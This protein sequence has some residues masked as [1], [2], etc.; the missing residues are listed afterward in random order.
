MKWLS[1]IFLVG[2]ISIVLCQAQNIKFKTYQVEDGLSNN[3]VNDFENDISGGL[4]IATWDG[5]NYFDGTNFQV[6]KHRPGD[7]SSLPGNFIFNLQLDRN[8]VL[9][10]KS[11]TQ[12]ISYKDGEGFVSFYF[13]Q[14]IEDFGLDLKGEL[15]LDVAG[16][17]FSFANGEF[18]SCPSC[19]SANRSPNLL[20]ELLTRN[21]PD[22]EINKVL[23]DDLGQ[24]WYAT[25]KNGLF[26]LPPESPNVSEH[27]FYNYT[28]DAFYPYSINSN[29]IYTIHEDVFGNVWVG[30]K[31]GGISMA[32]R[33]SGQIFSVFPHPTKNPAI[34]EETIRA[35]TQG[36]NGEIW[37]GYYNSGLFVSKDGQETF[38]KFHLDSAKFNKDWDRVRSLHTDGTGKIWVGTYA[39]IARIDL[40][41]GVRYFTADDN[42]YI[43]NNRNYNFAEADE[44][45]TLWVACWGGLAKYSVSEDAFVHFEG[46]EKLSPYNIRHVFDSN[47]I[48]YLATESNGVIIWENG[49]FRFLDEK[50]GL[51]SPSVYS[52]EKDAET[53]NIWIATMGGINI[54]HPDKGMLLQITELDGL[55]SQLVYG[56]LPSEDYMWASTTNG[57]SRISKKD[58]Q[59][60][61]LS[62]SE[63]WQGA[64][65]SEGGFYD[66]ERGVL[67]FSGVGGL[68]YFHPKQLLIKD[69]LPILGIVKP[70]PEQWEEYLKE[71][72]LDLKARHV[73]FTQT[74]QNKIQYQLAPLQSGWTD[75]G[76]DFR[77]LEASLAPGEYTLTL[78]NSQEANS[79]RYITLAITIPRPFWKSPVPWLIIG[80]LFVFS[81]LLWRSRNTKIQRQNL[82]KKVA[83]RTE[84][85]EKQKLELEKI[86][87]DLD[88]KNKEVSDQKATL[89]T[90]HNRHKDSDFEIEQFKN[91]MLGQF[92]LPLSELKENI[93]QLNTKSRVR[94]DV[95]LQQVNEIMSQIRDWDRATELERSEGYGTSLTILKPLLKDVFQ[96]IKPKLK[97]YQI[98]YEEKYQLEESWVEMDVMGF[99]LFWQYL[100][101]E[102]M[103]YLG[104]NS[105]LAV[106]ATS[107]QD[108]IQVKLKISSSLLTSNI[109]EIIKYSPYIKAAYGLLQKL[110]GNISYQSEEE[111]LYVS[112]LVPFDDPK[113]QVLNNP[114]GQWKYINLDKELDPDK[115]HVVLLGKKYE[116]DSLLKII[117]NEEF[118]II[119]EEDVH[120]VIEAIRNARI[121]ALVIYNEKISQNIIDL[122]EAIKATD[123]VSNHIPLVYIYDTIESG[124]Q[125]EL[126]DLGIET[127][128]Q[129]PASSRFILKNISTQLQNM[130]RFKK[131]FNRFEL[132]QDDLQDFS[133]PSEKLV[134]EGVSLINEQLSNGNFKVETLC[135]SLG[136]SKIKCYR[137]FKEVLNTSP[138]DVMMSLRLEKAQQLLSKNK[139]NV[140]EVSFACGFNDPKYFS[141]MFKKH[142]GHSPKNFYK[143]TEST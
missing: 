21:Y 11:T 14:E 128:I 9:W 103:K 31:D 107:S 70:E 37:L 39:G 51:L 102:I 119:V 88:A 62:P 98:R 73:S 7:P 29:E 52:F 50:D 82:L 45:A 106:Y 23:T 35:I 26:V 19:L 94:K 87:S 142:T 112:V 44:G 137:A 118:D 115:H 78:R 8:N 68:N 111:I 140:S 79:S 36:K 22:V 55:L 72:R 30:Y 20:E 61:T 60:K 133:S 66:N 114:V 104:E 10:V 105:S 12:S 130:K 86:N 58:F 63:G 116:S 108:S 3:S 6:Y 13:E 71:A 33:N 74:P 57:I 27:K 76:H 48:L 40:D 24:V 83:E 56:I 134:K 64:E 85:I 42:P 75:L 41:K 131:V 18:I 65:F 96:N 46:Q 81:L 25:M 80:V 53:G 69:D 143:P 132:L 125:D 92:R 129:L 100:L 32:Y 136:V 113:K 95:V 120:L 141:K 34:P 91:Y 17:T 84:V 16:E 127:F 47:G 4:W 93:E 28:A 101:R 122:I 2:S 77:I 121:N 99:K 89:L 126:M 138:S 117:H 139:M 109:D 90:L 5:L 43:P 15:Y 49:D 67:F 135:E 97:L 110:A 1:V 54:Y 124:F 59:V 123:K 38:K